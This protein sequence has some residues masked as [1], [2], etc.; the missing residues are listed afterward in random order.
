MTFHL[1]LFYL[2]KNFDNDN[3]IEKAVCVIFYV[4]TFE[5]ITHF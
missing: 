2:D 3:I 5:F 4:H 1:S